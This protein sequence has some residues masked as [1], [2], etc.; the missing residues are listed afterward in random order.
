MTK[1]PVLPLFRS[2]IF[3][4]RR[5]WMTW[6]LPL[7]VVVLAFVL[8]FIIYA[9]VQ[10]QIQALQ[11]GTLSTTNGPPP[12]TEAQLREELQTLRP[13]Q[14]MS[15]GLGVVSGFG[16]VLLIVFTASVFGN[17]FN[18]GTLR[19][20]LALGAGRERFL[21]AKYVALVLYATLLTIV[22]ALAALAGSEIVSSIA[23]LDST[24][25]SDFSTQLVLTIGRTVFTFLPYI[26]LAAFIAVWSKSGGAGIAIGLV[27]YFAEGIVMS[28]LVAFNKD[29]VTIANFGL[30]RNVSAIARL[31][32]SSSGTGP[33][34]STLPDPSQA[35]QAALVLLVYTMLFVGLT[36]WRFRVRDVTS[37]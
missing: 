5:R 23:S 6:I 22:G 4:L 18:W 28:L 12:Q 24:L 3:R 30:S 11:N 21:A 26:A 20:I 7:A 32:G 25:P 8:Y 29:Y 34:A 33:A 15:F 1:A 37:S 35:G 27:V 17:E 9:S 31:S 14:V 2:E 16:S 19:V 13:S 10:A 36:L